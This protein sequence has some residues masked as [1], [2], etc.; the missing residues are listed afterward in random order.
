MEL[1]T[2]SAV[3]SPELAALIRI[4]LILK[5]ILVTLKEGQAMEDTSIT[6]G[7]Q[8]RIAD[9]LL[10]RSGHEPFSEAE[11]D[12]LAQQMKAVL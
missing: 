5:A 1:K 4:E 3:Q 8:R 10:N 6:I 12:E 11:I 7:A 9:A 2:A